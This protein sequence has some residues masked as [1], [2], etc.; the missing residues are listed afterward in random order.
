MTMADFLALSLPIVP[1]DPL[2]SIPNTFVYHIF[3][4]SAAR[5]AWHSGS[6]PSGLQSSE[7]AQPAV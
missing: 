1:F 3:R 6:T 4:G 2:C 5:R 7:G